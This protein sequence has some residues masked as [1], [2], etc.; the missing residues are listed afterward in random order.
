MVELSWGA[1]LSIAVALLV[2]IFTYQLKAIHDINSTL[3]TQLTNINDSIEDVED[4]VQ[5]ISKSVTVIESKYQPPTPQQPQY[6]P[7]QRQ[8]AQPNQSQDRE[9]T[10]GGR[11]ANEYS[12]AEPQQLNDDF[13]A[14]DN[15][16]SL[17]FEEL[18]DKS[19]SYWEITLDSIDSTISLNAHAH[20]EGGMRVSYQLE[21]EIGRELVSNPDFTLGLKN[22]VQNLSP[23]VEVRYG[24]S[25]IEV[26]HVPEDLVGKLNYIVK[27]YVDSPQWVDESRRIT[28]PSREEQ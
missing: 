8:P 28:N 3:E 24:E 4:E 6:P 21:S 11:E 26:L 13:E 2:P 17:E 27:S 5:D 25:E 12:S 7:Q 16:P 1:L 14:T 19:P 23:S 22:E 20:D 18:E 10:D 15:M 9:E